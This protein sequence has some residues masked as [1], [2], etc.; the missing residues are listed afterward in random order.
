MEAK[1]L[2]D[3]IIELC[4]EINIQ[5]LTDAV[6]PIEDADGD[7]EELIGELEE[8]MLILNELS[9]EDQ[10]TDEIIRDIQEIYNE[11]YEM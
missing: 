9:G 6:L 3:N 8:V 7:A 10:V 11:L 2:F 1:E 5:L 4:Y